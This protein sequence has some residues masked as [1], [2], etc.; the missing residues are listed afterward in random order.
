M[1]PIMFY[2]ILQLIPLTLI[3][4]QKEIIYIKYDSLYHDGR[5]MEPYRQELVERFL[6]YNWGAGFHSNNFRCDDRYFYCDMI[7]E[8][9]VPDDYGTYQQTQSYI[10]GVMTGYLMARGIEVL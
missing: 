1:I 2:G 7:S 3:D 8:Y 9:Y 4:M 5:D 6:N 10:Q